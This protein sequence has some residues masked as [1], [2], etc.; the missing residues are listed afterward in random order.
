MPLGERPAT[1]LAPSSSLKN[2]FK[3][4]QLRFRMLHPTREVLDYLLPTLW[5]F[6]R[7]LA[8]DDLLR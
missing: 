8:T 7:A 3:E 1:I 4:I 2:R 6:A 5:G